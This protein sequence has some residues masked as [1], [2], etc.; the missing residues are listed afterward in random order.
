M[1]QSST[2][3]MLSVIVSTR[4]SQ[5]AE[6]DWTMMLFPEVIL[7]D[8]DKS[9]SMWQRCSPTY[10]TAGP[11][12]T[13]SQL[14]LLVVV[15]VDVSRYSSSLLRPPF[16]KLPCMRDH[17]QQLGSFVHVHEELFFGQQACNR[18]PRLCSRWYVPQLRIS[19]TYLL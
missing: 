12:E 1:P 6:E 10:F 5:V 14:L 4:A 7:L 18:I 11:L 9:G 19:G 3:G 13:H 16:R 17:V 8:I 2:H 15:S